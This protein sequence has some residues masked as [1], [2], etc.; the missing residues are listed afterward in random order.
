[1][2]VQTL[3]GRAI[4]NLLP[5]AIPT[6]LERIN[7]FAIGKV[8][9][10]KK[11]PRKFL[12]WRHHE[13]NFTGYSLPSLLADQTLTIAT[14]SN[15]LFDAGKGTSSATVKVNLDAELSL[16][17]SLVKMEARLKEDEMKNLTITTD[18]GKVSRI[19]TNLL[20][21]CTSRNL[22]VKMDHPIVKEA[23]DKGGTLFVIT[24]LYEAEHCKVEVKI[25]KEEDE[26]L[27]AGVS[28]EVGAGGGET[29]GDSKTATQRNSLFVP[30]C[31]Q[32]GFFFLFWR[33]VEE[34]KPVEEAQYNS[35]RV[36]C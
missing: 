10:Y 22:K 27:S 15:F 31:I 12:S 19:S 29:V 6:Q 26:T 18:V 17:E 2:S 9:I 21:D 3:F 24:S 5:S 33:I 25:A 30:L 16:R 36:V 14:S 23:I 28:A 8:L 20:P 35:T 32:D 4:S 13:L 1:M 11:K 7:E 34:G